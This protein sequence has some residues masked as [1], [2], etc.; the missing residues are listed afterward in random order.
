MD[1]HMNGKHVY[2]KTVVLAP[3]AKVKA[4]ITITDPRGQETVIRQTG[5]GYHDRN[6]GND[7]PALT[8]KGWIWTRIADK[9]LT[10]YFAIVPNEVNY[11]VYTPCFIAFKNK[12]ITST[13]A[14]EF[15]KEKSSSAEHG[16]TVA[17]TVKFLEESGVTGDLK[18]YDMEQIFQMGTYRQFKG[19]YA[20]DIETKTERITQRGSM[21]FED[22]DFSPLIV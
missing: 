4:D 20:L 13:E 3:T 11:P 18:F 21:L 9:D 17:A 5:L 8:V 22:V 14:V 2:H 16:Y 6:W 10:L 1:T 19:N 7:F 12:M 15:I